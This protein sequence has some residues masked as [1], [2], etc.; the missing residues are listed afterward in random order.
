[1][2]NKFRNRTKQDRFVSL[3]M[4]ATEHKMARA[5]NFESIIET[6]AQIKARRVPL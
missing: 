1:M 5:I 3:S 2:K 4:L 6:F